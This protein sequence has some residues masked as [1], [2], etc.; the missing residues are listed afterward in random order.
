MRIVVL[1]AHP[2]DPESGCGGLTVNA[3]R[4]EH[5]VCFVHVTAFRE[6]RQFFGRPEREART[7]EAN[8]AVYTRADRNKS[9]K[10]L[11]PGMNLKP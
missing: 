4:R 3:V 7:E 6:G 10:A 5:E 9:V 1:G 8:A 2:D 11:V